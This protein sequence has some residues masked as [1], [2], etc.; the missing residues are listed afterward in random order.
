M[1]SLG[2]LGVEQ[3]CAVCLDELN[4]PVSNQEA[5]VRLKASGFHPINIDLQDLVSKCQNSS[6]YRRGASITLAPQVVD[7]STL[8]KWL[9][10][11]RGIWIPRHSIHQRAMG[12]SITI[13]ELQPWDLVFSAGY[14]PYFIDNPADGVGHVGIVTPTGTIVHA[15]NSKVGVIEEELNVFSTP[16]RFRGAVRIIRPGTLTL[17]SLSARRAEC[18]YDFRC[19]VLQTLART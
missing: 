1:L 5:L 18:S 12:Q 15:A 10:G 6:Q 14:H 17:E 16:D 19:F 11:Q 2:Y 7:C 4:L 8:T 3:R 13:P 9:Y